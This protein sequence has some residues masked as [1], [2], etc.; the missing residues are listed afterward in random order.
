MVGDQSS[1]KSSLL[2]GIT[3][4]YFPVASDLCTRH[5]TQIVLRKTNKEAARVEFSIV[6][7]VTAMLKGGSRKETLEAF[8]KSLDVDATNFSLE[9]SM[10]IAQVLG[11]V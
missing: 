11:D 10:C 7:G 8:H 9:D 4:L 1:G 3:N 2:E 5:A 6:P